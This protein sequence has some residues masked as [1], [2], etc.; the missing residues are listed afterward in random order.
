EECA[1]AS[2]LLATMMSGDGDQEEL[3]R[4]PVTPEVLQGQPSQLSVSSTADIAN[5]TSNQP[6]RPQA[7]IRRSSLPIV[8]DDNA[9]SPLNGDHSVSSAIP[10]Q[11]GIRS[12]LESLSDSFRPEGDEHDSRISQRASQTINNKRK[13]NSP[14]A[15]DTKPLLQHDDHPRPWREE[16]YE[17]AQEQEQEQGLDQDQD[18][19]EYQSQEESVLSSTRGKSR[20]TL[21]RKHHTS[22]DDGKSVRTPK[23]ARHVAGLQGASHDSQSLN[24]SRKYGSGNHHGSFQQASAS[25]PSPPPSSPIEPEHSRSASLPTQHNHDLLSYPTSSSAS[26]PLM[27]LSVTPQ[28]HCDGNVN[29]ES[30]DAPVPP[31]ASRQK[32]ASRPPNQSSLDVHLLD[33]EGYLERDLKGYASRLSY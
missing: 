11:P 31:S 8:F 28:S 4:V 13:A 29:T 24:T 14:E 20:T 18:H 27:N 5:N 2:Q 19:K 1:S 3:D 10:P 16:V 22:D 33:I 17:Q 32:E 12:A 9:D 30:R 6:S 7:F 23:K 25:G 21:G 26:T 15:D